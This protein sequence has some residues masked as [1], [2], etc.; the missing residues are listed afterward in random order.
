MSI[1]AEIFLLSIKVNMQCEFWTSSNGTL[2]FVRGGE[3]GEIF[4]FCNC[5]ERPSVPAAAGEEYGNEGGISSKSSGECSKEL[6]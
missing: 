2:S 3:R 1:K 4:I 6:T 5:V